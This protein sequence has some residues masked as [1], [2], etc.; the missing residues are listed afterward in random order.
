MLILPQSLSSQVQK[1][2]H[3]ATSRFL[4]LTCCRDVLTR[5]ERCV[6]R[7]LKPSHRQRASRVQASQIHQIQTPSQQSQTFQADQLLLEIDTNSP[8]T[9][10]PLRPAVGI[11]AEMET[12][13]HSCG[14]LSRSLTWDYSN[15]DMYSDCFGSSD[16]LLPNGDHS[17]L[18]NQNQTHE[19]AVDNNEAAM[20]LAGTVDS[21]M[22]T[23]YNNISASDGAAGDQVHAT[24][25]PIWSPGPTHGNPS[26]MDSVANRY[27]T[28][29]PSDL[30]SPPTS[31]YMSCETSMKLLELVENSNVNQSQLPAQLL[32]DDTVTVRLQDAIGRG[33]QAKNHSLPAKVKCQRYIRSFFQYFHFHMPLMHVPTFQARNLPSAL[34]L[35]MLAI[36]ALYSFDPVE[37]RALHDISKSTLDLDE[38]SKRQTVYLQTLLYIT[39]FIYGSDDTTL[40]SD[41]L[42]FQARLARV[43][44]YR[45][46]PTPC[47]R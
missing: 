9:T 47:D 29:N 43:G 2:R 13:L 1:I 34:L 15:I 36:G 4:R 6:H 21:I 39:C 12:Q 16:T 31:D 19:N 38:G 7:I 37:A 30:P 28:L 44:N 8:Q 5:H 17:L 24:G 18:P 32:L 46:A 35:S 41:G 40:R 11:M 42:K 23:M 45:N 3:S 20:D 25:F 27:P 22:S 26:M 33:S 14:D 10:E